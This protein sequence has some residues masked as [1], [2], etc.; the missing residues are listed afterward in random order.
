MN[1]RDQIILWE[2]VIGDI[3]E[4]KKFCESQIKWMPIKTNKNNKTLYY[5]SLKLD[6]N[7]FLLSNRVLSFQT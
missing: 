3:P 5:S 4:L 6:G 7:G 1:S 2:T